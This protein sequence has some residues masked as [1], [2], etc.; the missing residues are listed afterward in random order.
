MVVSVR[1]N[2]ILLA[3]HNDALFIQQ[4]FGEEV[5]RDIFPD[6]TI[7]RP[8]DV[9]GHED[10]FLRYYASLRIFPFGMI[11]LLKGGEGVVK[12]PVYVSIRYIIV[13]EHSKIKEHLP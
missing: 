3:I 6:V 8:A 12:R 4:A 10:R 2:L 1:S 11:P 13:E 9:Y 5:V 7:V